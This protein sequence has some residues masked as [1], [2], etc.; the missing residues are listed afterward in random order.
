M[1]LFGSHQKKSVVFDFIFLKVDYINS[2]TFREPNKRIKIVSMRPFYIWVFCSLKSSNVEKLF[3]WIGNYN[4]RYGIFFQQNVGFNCLQRFG[5]G[6]CRV[7]KLILCPPDRILFR[8]NILIFKQS[9]R[10]CYSRCC[11]HV[12]FILIIFL[13]GSKFAVTKISLQASKY[14]SKFTFFRVIVGRP[15]FI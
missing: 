1:N 4:V 6:K 9:A 13:F 12:L 2:C 14:S 15:N 7:L 8:Y 5:Y 11:A 10:I 3:F